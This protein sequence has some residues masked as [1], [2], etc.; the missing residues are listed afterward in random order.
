MA[1]LTLG[2]LIEAYVDVLTLHVPLTDIFGA[3]DALV[4]RDA[5]S[6]W[7]TDANEN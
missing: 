4:A 5:A 6:F 1:D 2:C 7:W 3:V